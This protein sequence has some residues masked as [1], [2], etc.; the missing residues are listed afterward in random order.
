MTTDG[1]LIE[2]IKKEFGTL[3]YN[4]DGELDRTYMSRAVFSDAAKL[5]RLNSLV[6]PRVAADYEQWVRR[7]GSVPYVLKEAALLIE[8]GT[9]HQLDSLIVVVAP[10]AIRISRVLRR[11]AHRDEKQVKEIMKNQLSDEE[12]MQHAR[13]TILNDEKHSLIDQVLRLHKGFLEQTN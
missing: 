6:H 13:H 2:A 9:H 10:E 4:T 7:Q 11:D 3:S 5:A 8:A 12:R 1:I